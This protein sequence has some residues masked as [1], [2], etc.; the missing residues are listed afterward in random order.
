MWRLSESETSGHCLQI[1]RMDIKDLFDTIGCVGVEIGFECT[2]GLPMQVLVLAYQQLELLLD[3]LQFALL[4]LVLVEFHFGL[5][6]MP[7]VSPL[8][9]NK[10]EQ[11]LARGVVAPASPPN[12]MY[13]LLDIEGR[14]V[15]DYPVHLR[16]I[17]TPCCY[18][19]A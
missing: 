3:F 11:S 2:C 16:D 18:I 8:L 6:Q 9:F 12:S 13:I 1:E 5:Q 4:E 19:R 7:Q 17:E 15:L 14:I 10:Y